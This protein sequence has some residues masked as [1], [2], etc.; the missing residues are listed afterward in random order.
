MA[1]DLFGGDVVPNDLAED[2][3]LADAPRDQ[4]RVLGAKIQY[5]NALIRSTLHGAEAKEKRP[6]EGFPPRATA[7]LGA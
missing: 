5:E 2:V 4:L 7:K 1:A 3:G 6:P